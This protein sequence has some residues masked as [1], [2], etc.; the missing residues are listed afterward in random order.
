MKWR[1]RI[2]TALAILWIF[3]QPAAAQTAGPTAS[4]STLSFSYQVNSTTYPAAA[5]VTITLPKATG[6]LPLVVTPPAQGWL[7]VTP[8]SG[9]SPLTLSVLVNPTGLTPGSY[10][11]VISVDSVPASHSPAVIAVTLMV[12]NPPSTLTIGS[13]SSNYTP[14][15]SGAALPSLSFTYTTG[16]GAI[17]PA[18]SEIDVSTTGSDAI[19]FNVTAG[20]GTT[21]TTGVWLRV[22]GTG[23]ALPNLTTSGVALSGSSVPST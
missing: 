10:P 8:S 23:G 12:S 13:P 19:S 22:N 11:G 20:G 3:S 2:S 17:S 1:L 5:K 16:S 21:K 15:G 18:Q 14:S 6:S 7:I 9:H 4:P